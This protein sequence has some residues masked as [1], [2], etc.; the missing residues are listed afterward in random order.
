MNGI[1]F[2]KFI[3]PLLFLPYFC[4]ALTTLNFSVDF[5]NGWRGFLSLKKPTFI[6]SLKV[7]SCQGTNALVQIGCE[8]K[9]LDSFYCDNIP[10]DEILLDDTYYGDCGITSSDYGTIEFQLT[11]DF[12]TITTS[13]LSEFLQDQFLPTLGQ[14]LTDI[15][16]LF[17]MIIGIV[18]AFVFLKGFIE[19][20]KPFFRGK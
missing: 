19:F 12:E 15:V 3:I 20:F 2:L 6:H 8:E 14:I 9:V 10:Q 4:F 18:I 7:F 11:G 5:V 1:K 13:T 17:I 16:P